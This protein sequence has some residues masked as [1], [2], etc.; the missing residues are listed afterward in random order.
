MYDDK[1]WVVGGHDANYDYQNDVWY[2]SDGETWTQATA[3]APFS[4]RREH[5]SVVFDD[6]VWVIGG[7]DENKGRKNDVWAFE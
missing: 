7:D 2:S 5:T 6:K 4:A 1:L 3:A